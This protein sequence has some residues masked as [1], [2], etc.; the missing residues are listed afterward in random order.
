MSIAHPESE[1][2]KWSAFDVCEAWAIK[3]GYTTARFVNLALTLSYETLAV[4]MEMYITSSSVKFVLTYEI[5]F[6]NV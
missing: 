1:N 5:T 4:K 6:V 2:A 3:R